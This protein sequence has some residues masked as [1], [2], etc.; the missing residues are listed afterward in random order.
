MTVI[1][2]PRWPRERLARVGRD[3][4]FAWLALNGLPVPDRIYFDRE[5]ANAARRVED[6]RSKHLLRPEW[7][8][9]YQRTWPGG[10][11]AIAVDVQGC[12]MEARQRPSGDKPFWNAPGSFMDFT[13]LGVFC[14]EVGHHVDFTLHP[15]AYSRQN[16]FEEVA[17]DEEEISSVE[18]NVLESFAEAIRLFITNPDLLQQG[19]PDRYEYL[20]RGMGLKAL[21]LTGWRTVLRNA[22]KRVRSSAE[23][24]LTP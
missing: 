20:T 17:D 16:G 2:D 6:P 18:H 4:S 14:H 7:L 23:A 5:S 15:K 24:W 22:G 3:I 1:L 19:R 8:G 9:V 12:H 21:H 11:N 10:W 13:P